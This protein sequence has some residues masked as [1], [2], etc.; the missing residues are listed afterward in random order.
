MT[1]VTGPRIA[2]V[3][4]LFCWPPNG[5]ADVDV[6]H[7]AMGLAQA[8]WPVRLFLPHF[9]GIMGRGCISNKEV[10][11]DITQVTMAAEA[12]RE[13]VVNAL[14]DAV[15]AWQ[16]DGVLL[17]H[18]YALK[19]FVALAL[20]HY[21]VVGRYYAHE[22]LCAR[23]AFRFKDNEPCP[24]NYIDNPDHC[25]QCALASLA[26]EIRSGRTQAW[27]QEYLL[28]EAYRTSYHETVVK[29][30]NTLKRI[31]V[32]NSQ[33][34]ATLPAYQDKTVVIPGGV[35]PGESPNPLPSGK[36]GPEG[37]KIILM[38]GRVEDPAKGLAL[39]LEAGAK[40]FTHRQDFHILA[41]H[42]DPM[43]RGPFFSST[44]WLP[45]EEARRL[46]GRADICVVPSLWQEP[47]GLVA[48][49]AMAAGVPVC[50]ADCGGL[51]DSVQTER[52]GL[53]FKRGDAVDLARCLE[54]LLDDDTLRARMGTAGRERAVAH[55]TWPTIVDKHYLPLIK[56]VL[57]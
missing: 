31:V 51:H 20:A 57:L 21:P 48:V 30:M 44:G 36:F 45:Y 4:L 32:Y 33:L 23:D 17:T 16:P 46:Y 13:T 54:R 47:F 52:T 27:V 19:P 53:L 29:A 2:I 9:S 7:M 35:S 11:I 14:R 1:V 24:Y 12:R 22:L 43:W 8:G 39:L 6:Y 40:L 18:G 50:A 49:E 42:F 10:Q 15:D 34:R 55:Y 41:T 38:P 5:G 37:K 3:D 25:R 26:P 28:A 56:S